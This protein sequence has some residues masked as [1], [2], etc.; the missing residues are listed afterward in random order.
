LRTK[1]ASSSHGQMTGTSAPM[2]AVYE[3]IA[4]IANGDWT[5]LIQGETG[6]GKELVAR[7]VHAASPRN[8]GPF[9]AV[10]CA[11]LTD[12][13]L[14]SQLFGHRKG[15]F[16]GAIADQQGLFEAA[17]G[18]TI[19]L[20]EIGD[21]SMKVQTSLLR[22]IQEREVLRSR[23]RKVDCRVLVATNRDLSQEVAAGRFRED[24]LY[25]IRVAR[26]VVPPLRERAGDVPLLVASFLA[27]QRLS[28]GRPVMELEDEA[29]N[30]LQ[31]HSWP[32]NVRE[33]KSAIEH[34]VIRCKGPVICLRDLPPELRGEGDHVC[35]VTPAVAP[36]APAVSP[37]AA[38]PADERGRILE[39]RAGPRG[40]GHGPPGGSA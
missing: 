30:A 35:A 5:V 21:V 8:G 15:A 10:N 6:V 38:P 7:A 24:L 13:L 2:R 27:Q 37:E 22:V 4:D 33:L 32:G 19:L 14:E 36:A 29:M 40:T 34:A 20:D 18:G 3:Q 1:L 31:R 23:V 25:R 16:T 28:T 26:I 11:G 39:A 9:I 17:A 12:S